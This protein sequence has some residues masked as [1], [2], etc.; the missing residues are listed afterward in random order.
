[1]SKTEQLQ[2]RVSPAQKRELRMAAHRAGLSV[3]ELVL[4]R[5]LPSSRNRFVALVAALGG[6]DE[7]SKRYVLAEIG[8]VLRDA[9]QREF[10]T[11]VAEEPD[12]MPSRYWGTYLAASI[13]QICVTRGCAIP[14]WVLA[15]GPLESPHFGTAL[16]SLRLHLLV[17][18]PAA[19]RRRNLF[20]DS[21]S[22]DRV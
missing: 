8:D 3:S 22:A 11:M 9:S 15:I 20:I 19:F 18:S 7:E 21:T 2:I 12:V 16:N 4:E 1:M 6:G 13:E 5:A 17:S 10:R 14:E